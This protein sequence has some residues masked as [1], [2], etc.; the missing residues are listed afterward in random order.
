MYLLR[1]R[2][3]AL[4]CHWLVL[5]GSDHGHWRLADGGPIG[6]PMGTASCL[7]RFLKR[8]RSS[9]A[10]ASSLHTVPWISTV[11]RQ[12]SSF[13]RRYTAVHAASQ[14]TYP[15]RG[16]P[17]APSAM[18]RARGL[19]HAALPNASCI[20]IYYILRTEKIE[21]EIGTQHKN[22][23]TASSTR[24]LGRPSTQLL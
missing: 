1:Y 13:P 3:L 2:Y 4:V 11:T 12:P 24:G 7:S 19:A 15:S 5:R 18:E 10:P 6:N 14:H 8:S 9:A 20:C 22:A 23:G 21:I 16:G 17:R